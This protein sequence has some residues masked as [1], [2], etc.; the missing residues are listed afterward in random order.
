[1]HHFESL[2]DILEIGRGLRERP[3]R[4]LI[5]E[6]IVFSYSARGSENPSEAMRT[7]TI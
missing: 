3:D 2:G 1:M 5:R 6:A 7:K 4:I